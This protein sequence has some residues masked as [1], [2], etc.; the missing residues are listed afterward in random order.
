MFDIF[1]SRLLKLRLLAGTRTPSTSNIFST[2]HSSNG[3]SCFMS[4]PI[5]SPDAGEWPQA[6]W[7]QRDRRFFGFDT[8]GR[9]RSWQLQGITLLRARGK[10]F[11]MVE[12]FVWL[13]GQN[14]KT[15]H[16]HGKPVPPNVPKRER[17]CADESVIA[18]FALPIDARSVDGQDSA[19]TLTMAA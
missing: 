14:N 5:S 17:P 11:G 18:H 7:R 19:L 6:K 12:F 4:L 8:E 3:S 2:T 9:L 13:C 15:G 16:Y 10:R 1:P